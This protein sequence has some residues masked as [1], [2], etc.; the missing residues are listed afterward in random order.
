MNV[1]YLTLDDD[2]LVAQCAVDHYRS[3]GPGGQKR[4]KTSSAVRLRHTPTGL[5]VTASEDRS[6]HV[7][8]K[9]AIRRLREAIALNV[10]RPIELSAYLMDP[11]IRRL[12]R[13]TGITIGPRDPDYFRVVREVLD[14]LAACG[15]RVSEAAA[16]LGLST[17][18]LVKLVQ[19]DPKLWER[20]NQLRAQTGAKPLR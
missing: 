19:D 2:A 16:V 10:R 14:V 18:Q 7:N 6:Q 12:L 1:D 3:S 11:S 5:A 17:A 4:N 20:V 8:R 13:P 15:M 9:R